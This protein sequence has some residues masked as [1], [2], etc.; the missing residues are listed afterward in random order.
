MASE[1]RFSDGAG[2]SNGQPHQTPEVENCRANP[3]LSSRVLYDDPL[4]LQ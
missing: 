4:L 1:V 3:E 2:P